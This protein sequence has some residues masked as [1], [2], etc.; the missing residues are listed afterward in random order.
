MAK[1]GIGTAG[2]GNPYGYD[3]PPT[4]AEITKI[5]MTAR[6][7]GIEIIDT[8]PAYNVDVDF[9]GF[10]V[11]Q[12]TPYKGDCYA[13]LQ[14]DPDGELPPEGNY[15]RGISV[16]TPE[17]LLRVIDNIDIVQIPLSIADNRFLPFLPKLRNKGVEIHA[18]S[19]FMRGMLLD[20]L[21]VKTCLGYVLAQNVDYVIVGV[22]SERQLREACEVG[23]VDVEPIVIDEGLLDLRRV[24]NDF[25]DN[26]GAHDI[27]KTAGQVIDA[28]CGKAAFK[29]GS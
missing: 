7:R 26:S 19:V 16:Y 25:S 28:P 11:V 21:D 3:T 8:A 12:K 1:I 6:R 15:K 22:N 4:R 2:W 5:L 29:V 10:K 24:A 14:H 27:S 20:R 18:R 17:Q 9:S 13:L 23:P